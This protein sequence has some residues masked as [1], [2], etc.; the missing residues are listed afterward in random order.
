[1]Y[2]KI[3]IYSLLFLLTLK[4]K[5]LMIMFFTSLLINT[6]VDAYFNKNMLIISLVNIIVIYNIFT[7][8]LKNIVTTNIKVKPTDGLLSFLDV[9]KKRS[10]QDGILCS[11]LAF[12]LYF[13][14][15]VIFSLHQ[16]LKNYDPKSPQGMLVYLTTFFVL[17]LI[18]I[19][20]SGFKEFDRK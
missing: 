9:F 7:Y 10:C 5:A 13:M 16:Y 4:Y 14:I 20:Y 11:S 15:Y 3:I 1:M 8:C 6:L 12:G 19:F 17:M 2:A 18:F